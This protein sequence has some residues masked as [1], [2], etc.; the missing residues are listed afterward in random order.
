MSSK[1]KKAL[2]VVA[3]LMFGLFSAS[4]L[5]KP[6]DNIHIE[7]YKVRAGDTFWN[8]TEYYRNLDERDLYIFDFMDEV[9]ELN[10]HL[11]EKN[12]QLQPG[13]MITVKYVKK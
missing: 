3:V 11:V 9:R 5:D 2:A 4:V 10:P 7:T 6:Q 12:C 1:L 8:V 13:D